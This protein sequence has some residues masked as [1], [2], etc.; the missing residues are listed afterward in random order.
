[1]NLSPKML[2]IC[3]CGVS[4]HFNRVSFNLGTVCNINEWNPGSQEEHNTEASTDVDYNHV[5]LL[6]FHTFKCL[7]RVFSAQQHCFR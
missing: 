7:K 4:V 1:M 6:F 5:Y 3:L 2:I